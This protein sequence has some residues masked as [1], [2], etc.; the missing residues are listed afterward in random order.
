MILVL[1]GPSGGFEGLARGLEGEGRAVTA[2]PAA[3]LATMRGVRAAVEAVRPEAV[4]LAAEYG[5]REGCEADED[6]AFRENAEAAINLAAAALEF[7]AVPV[8]VS[9]AEVFGQSGGPWSEA[10]TPQP[11]SVYAQSKLRGEQ[12]LARAAP[13]A[14]VVRVGPVLDDGLPELAARLQDDVEAADD[15]LVSPVG[16]VDLGR[17]IHALLEARISGVVHV[18]NAGA[19]VSRAE[20]FT[21][22]ARALG[23]D[24]ERV[25]GRSGRAIEGRAPRPRAATLHTDRL[26]KALDAPLR[27]WLAALEEAA[28]AQPRRD[29]G[30]PAVPL[31]A[32]GEVGA[33]E[34]FTPH[35]SGRDHGT[36]LELARAEDHHADLLSLDAGKQLSARRHP[37]RARTLHVISGKVLL[38]ALDGPETDHVLRP[39]RSVTVPAGAAYRLTAVDAAQV[40]MIWAGGDDTELA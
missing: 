12:F 5:D 26:S 21:R 35:P 32:G 38:E 36:A 16:A 24:P 8:L 33:V 13:N 9:T 37:R 1:P 18:A 29:A 4:I 27:S 15:E 22:A 10:D 3:D 2:Q 34:V 30:A 28:E 14:L 6:R 31:A 11:P 40:L 23:I 17:A 19:P 7:G 25:R 39:G 20:L